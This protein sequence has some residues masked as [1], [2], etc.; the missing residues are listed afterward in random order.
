MASIHRLDAYMRQLRLDPVAHKI[1]WTTF[2]Q[3]KLRVLETTGDA[4]AALA[5]IEQT[6][7]DRFRPADV[8]RVR[9]ARPT[10]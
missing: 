9:R 8:A 1:H 3:A 4:E 10:P 7:E 6:G 5:F 2:Y